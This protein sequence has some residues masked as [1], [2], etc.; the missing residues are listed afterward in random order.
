[1]K[2]TAAEMQRA[3]DSYKGPLKI[4]VGLNPGGDDKFYHIRLETF[5]I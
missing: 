3:F 1:M 5:L 2:Q 4:H